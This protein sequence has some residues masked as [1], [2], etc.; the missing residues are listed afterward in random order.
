MGLSPEQRFSQQADALTSMAEVVIDERALESIVA[1]LSPESRQRLQSTLTALKNNPPPV[2]ANGFGPIHFVPFSLDLCQAKLRSV[3]SRLS[4]LRQIS[5]LQEILKR[6]ADRR[7]KR[8]EQ[9]NQMLREQ[10]IELDKDRQRLTGQLRSLLGIK[11][12]TSIK[13]PDAKACEPDAAEKDADKKK[14]RG[15]PRGHRGSTRTKPDKV[16]RTITINPPSACPHC[17]HDTIILSENYISKYIEDIPPIIK[18][19]TENQYFHGAC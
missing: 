10:V 12:R 18:T 9:E 3:L 8:F 14:K 16:D 15:A 19:V 2:S 4:W 5:F 6:S 17:Q 7:T 1:L 11:K 13:K